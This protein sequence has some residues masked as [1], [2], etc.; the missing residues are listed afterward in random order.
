M[1][2]K[3]RIHELLDSPQSGHDIEAL[4]FATIDREAPPH[5]FSP[6]QW[7]IVRRMIH[8]TADFSIMD[9]VRFSNDA[10][11]AGIDAL[12]AGR[13]LFVDSNMIRAGLSVSRLQRVCEH[14]DRNSIRCHVADADVAEAANQEGLPRS[15]L[16]VQKAGTLLDGAIAVF[17][18]APTALLE[19]NRMIIEEGLQPA[20][21]IAAP[22]G[23]VHVRESKQELMELEVPHIALADRRGGSPIAV[24]I[25]HA[26]CTL[27]AGQ[28]HH[29][30]AGG[31]SGR[32]FDAVILLGH[33]S[34]VPDAGQSMQKVAET[35][36]EHGRYTVVETCHMSRL[37]PH[38]EETLDKCVQL[39]A[40]NVL[41]LPYFLNQG[42]HIKLDI[43]EMMQQ[44]AGQ[45]PQVRLTF[46]KNLGYD[47][48]LVQLVE[49]RIEE[50]RKLDDVRQAVLPSEADYPIPPGQ[51]EFVPMHP[52]QA[53]SWKQTH[54]DEK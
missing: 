52:Q 45:Y 10:I 36:R 6:A 40:R 8:T 24:S 41:V 48:L 51:C 38:F 44:A 21:V 37:G 33:G 18:N 2:R 16:A 34:R 54:Q 17:G 11:N 26:L 15:V 3:S 42:L 31:P 39:G 20:L 32:D 9:W 46:G 22:V 19:L 49:K 30:P 43:P 29:V 1:T 47:P 50:S 4:S 27:A 35:L 14:Y 25:V 13:P 5:R 53:A 12:R 7:E 23:F 28:P